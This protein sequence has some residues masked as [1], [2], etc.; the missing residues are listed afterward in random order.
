MRTLAILAMGLTLLGAGSAAAQ[1]V[2]DPSPRAEELAARYVELFN[3]RAM[4]L[5]QLTDA[6][7]LSDEMMSGMEALGVPIKGDEAATTMP[8]FVPD[9]SLDSMEPMIALMES[10]M[11]QAVAETYPEAE[12]EAL[13]AFYDTE[14]GRSI[15]DRQGA[16]QLRMT[17]LMFERMP[18]M[19]AAMG[20]DT[21]ALGDLYG[22]GGGGQ[23]EVIGPPTRQMQPNS[24]SAQGMSLNDIMTYGA[25]EDD[26]LMVVTEDQWLEEWSED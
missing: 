25:L 19:M 9:G 14:V 16:L 13:V 3:L 21:E 10:V 2:L 22:L 6:E 23:V 17:G 15:M 1:E 26:L 24:S 11:V 7:D 8:T 4:M 12:L 18:E 20:V 5:Q